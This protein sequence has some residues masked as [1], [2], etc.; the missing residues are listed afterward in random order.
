MSLERTQEL[1]C[2]KTGMSCRWSIEDWGDGYG[3]G[4][5][6]WNLWCT[7]C[8]R[9]RDWGKDDMSVTRIKG[10]TGQSEL[11]AVD[12]SEGAGPVAV[13]L[14]IKPG[15]VIGLDV[16]GIAA[17]CAALDK[18]EAAYI[19]RTIEPILARKDSAC[20]P[21]IVDRIFKTPACEAFDKANNGSRY[22]TH[23]EAYEVCP[24]IRGAWQILPA[25]HLAIHD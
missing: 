14:E 12:T 6:D 8:R 21:S 18:A 4:L 20:E 11:I 19:A 17:L 1:P 22:N 9:P 2:E 25:T 16:A 15:S 23:I 5:S 10:T 3:G 13:V 7:D 24:S